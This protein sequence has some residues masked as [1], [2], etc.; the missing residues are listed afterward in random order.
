[1]LAALLVP[2]WA[3]VADEADWVQQ[4]GPERNGIIPTSVAG[5]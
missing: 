2:A 3:C 4:M 1:M 5:S